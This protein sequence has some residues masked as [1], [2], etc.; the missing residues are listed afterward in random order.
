[1]IVKVLGSGCAKCKVLEKKVIDLK[2][3]H[4]LD[5]DIKKVTQIKDIMTYGVMM[6]PALVI[7]E[8]VKSS[9]KIPKEDDILNWIRE[10]K[11]SE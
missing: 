10:E 7:N 8:N 3:K 6:T 2:A 5:I 11:Y 4:A 1:M 9:G